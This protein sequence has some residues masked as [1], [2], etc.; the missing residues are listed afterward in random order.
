MGKYL[1]KLP[2]MGESVAEA[3]LTAWL[4]D[5]GDSISID[6]SIVEVA[7]DK[8]DSDIPSEV[9]GVLIEKRFEVNQIAQV[10]DVIGVIEVAGETEV[11]EEEEVIDSNVSK[12]EVQ[13]ITADVDPVEIIEA[14]ISHAQTIINTPIISVSDTSRFYSPLV[15]NIAKEEGISIDEL[16]QVPGTGDKGRV[17]K[18]DILAYIEGRANSGSEIKYIP[19]QPI[20]QIHSEEPPSIPSGQDQIIQMTRMGKMISDHMVNSRKTS[21]HV[22][23]FFEV[24]VTDLWDWRE[25]VKGKFQAREQEKLTFTPIF[26]AAVVKA[27]K[28]FPLLN[29]SVSG[30]NIIQKK[31][32]NIGMATALSDGNLIVPVIKNTDHLNLVG[33]ARAVNDLSVRARDNKLSPDEVQDGT[34]TVTNVG[35]F[36]SITGI[37]IINQPQV[38]ILAIGV[39]RKMPAVIETPKGDFI[40]IRRKMMLCHSYDH[41]IINGAMGGQFVKAVGDALE[42]WDTSIDF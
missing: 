36:G 37:P 5:V 4:K 34:Y 14:D 23:S 26:I 27:L 1:L 8:V 29:S 42:H 25:R 16:D 30:D 21:A 10:G 18:K 38:G 17:T 13:G 6:E 24:D 20:S 31:N 3:T 35:N 22:Q 2:K 11:I 12:P 32:I 7:T 33:L 28:E 41:R 39:I 40:G 9:E 19:T 15:K